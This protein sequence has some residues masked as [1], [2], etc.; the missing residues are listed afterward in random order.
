MTEITQECG[1]T[2]GLI[3]VN[4]LNVFTLS[5]PAIAKQSHKNRIASSLRSSQWHSIYYVCI[6][7]RFLNR[8]YFFGFICSPQQMMSHASTQPQTVSTDTTNPHARQENL[9]PFVTAFFFVGIG[10]FTGA[11]FFG[12]VAKVITPFVLV[13]LS[14]FY[15]ESAYA[16]PQLILC[17]ENMLSFL[18][19]SEFRKHK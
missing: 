14:E 15:C 3:I 10:F 17:K 7:K 9:L 13:L 16:D 12:F 4:A 19:S 18:R 2:F 8:C 6:S 1:F 11:V 5:L